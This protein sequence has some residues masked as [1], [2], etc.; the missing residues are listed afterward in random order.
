LL[1]MTAGFFGAHSIASGWVGAR[2]RSG[3]AQATSL[4]NLFYYAGSSLFGWLGGLAFL[5]GWI[6][7]AVMVACLAGCALLVAV[8]GARD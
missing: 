8:S 5:A 3:R 7:T 1:V 4:Y 6:G 2:A